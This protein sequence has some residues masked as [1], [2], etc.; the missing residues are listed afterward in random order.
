MKRKYVGPLIFIIIV[1]FGLIAALL[2][3]LTLYS[4][5]QTD[6]SGSFF[7]DPPQVDIFCLLM[8]RQ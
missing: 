5:K 2:L 6:I 7:S 3:V 4:L 1:V 8:A